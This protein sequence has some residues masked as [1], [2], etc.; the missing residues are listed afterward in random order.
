MQPFEAF[1]ELTLTA[2]HHRIYAMQKRLVLL[3]SAP[4]RVR[5]LNFLATYPTLAQRLPLKLIAVYLGITPESLSRVR[6]ELAQGKMK[7]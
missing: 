3:L 7:P 6:H 4:A 1:A 2:F 5:Y